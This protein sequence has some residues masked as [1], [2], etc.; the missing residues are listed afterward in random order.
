MADGAAA[1]SP[2]SDT[3]SGVRIVLVTAPDAETGL[4]LVREVVGARLAACGNLVPG[5]TSVYRWKGEIHQDPECLVILK[6][7]AA[8]VG[9]LRTR[10]V[11]LH[12]YEVPEFLTL[13]VLDGHPPYLAWVEG[14]V[15]EAEMP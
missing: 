6:T 2:G 10:V 13:P 15:A 11:E 12:P 4:G 9:D 8:L 1:D 5:L 7:T 14:E 3:R